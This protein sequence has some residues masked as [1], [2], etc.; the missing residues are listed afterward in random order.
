MHTDNGDTARFEFPWSSTVFRLKWK[1]RDFDK[2]LAFPFV[3]W[4]SVEVI[5]L[6]CDCDEVCVV[7]ARCYRLAA[8]VLSRCHAVSVLCL[9]SLSK[10]CSPLFFWM[11]LCPWAHKPGDLSYSLYISS[12]GALRFDLFVFGC[13]EDFWERWCWEVVEIGLSIKSPFL[14]L[15]YVIERE[16]AACLFHTTTRLDSRVSLG[17]KISIWKRNIRSK[18]A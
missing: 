3:L 10:K 16:P 6:L 5:K 14:Y 4:W 13:T 9:C 7:F 15:Y 18:H 12:G 11:D 17:P 8:W 2:I 1:L